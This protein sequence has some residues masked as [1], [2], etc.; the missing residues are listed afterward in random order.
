MIDNSAASQLTIT[1][2]SKKQRRMALKRQREL[3]AKVMESGD[4]EALAPKI[5]LQHQTLNL[6]LG[7]E[8]VDGQVDP[9][10]TLLDNTLEAAAKR[11]ALRVALRKERRTKIKEDNFLRSM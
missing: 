4:L 5:P 6:P 7:V 11:K 3:E 2:K 8:T 9:S 10:A 1:A